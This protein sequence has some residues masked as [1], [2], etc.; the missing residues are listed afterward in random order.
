MKMNQVTI[1]NKVIELVHHPLHHLQNRISHNLIK[2][3]KINQK[4]K[5]IKSL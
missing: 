3:H 1:A 5:L 4:I 2:N